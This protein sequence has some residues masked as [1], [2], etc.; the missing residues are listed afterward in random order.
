M[1]V[2]LAIVGIRNYLPNG[3]KD[4]EELFQRLP[5]GTSVYL[6]KESTGTRF[7][8]S[9]TVLDDEGNK[10]GN[11]SKTE[12][13][14]IEQD[15][16]K[17]RMLQVKISGHSRKHNCMFLTADNHNGVSKP[18]LRESPL[19]EGETTIELTTEDYE[20]QKIT[21]LMKTK[22]DKVKNRIKDS[23]PSLIKIAKKY[24]KLC[25]ISLD[26][27]T[28]F[29]RQ[30]IL[31]ELR[32]LVKIYPELTEVYSQIFEAHKDLGRSYNDVKVDVYKEQ[33][34]RIFKSA[35]EKNKYGKSL[36]DDYVENIKFLNSGKLS[37]EKL[38]QRIAHLEEL[39]SKELNNSYV[40]NVRSDE[41]FATALY[42]LN[43]TMQGIYRMF[44]RKIR[45]A[46]LIAIR[47]KLTDETDGC[48]TPNLLDT[49]EAQ[50]LLQKAINA[51][52]LDEKLQPTNKLATKVSKAVFANIMANKLSIPSPMYEPFEKLWNIQNLDRSYS[53]GNQADVNKELAKEIKE[54]L[55]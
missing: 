17:G 29:S 24:T 7:P 5:I 8:G 39:L 10:I 25:C 19:E 47:K 31:I 1:K 28:S 6:I 11:V 35:S 18:F 44:T 45:L 52:W 51:G 36:L 3:E 16:P 34:N 20:L 22:I 21:S 12:R 15:I 14:Y 49:Q 27:E 54:S 53:S 37:I 43:Y 4:Y 48:E 30:D 55:K 2:T 13:R 50:S 23:I 9:V 40:K 46:H 26:G 38:D 32:S 33:Y 41:D 42:S